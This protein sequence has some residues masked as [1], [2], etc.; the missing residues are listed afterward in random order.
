MVEKPTRNPVLCSKH[1]TRVRK[2]DCKFYSLCLDFAVSQRWLN[3][4][5]LECLSFEEIR[6]PIQLHRS[7]DGEF[8]GTCFSDG[9]VR[10]VKT[11]IAD[12]LDLDDCLG[13]FQKY[14]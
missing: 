14:E 2:P 4:T 5:C 6:C 3:F 10:Q 12:T 1:K 7:F 9:K 13:F 8:S 11:R